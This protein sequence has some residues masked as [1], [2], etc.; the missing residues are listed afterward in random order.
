MINLLHH[1]VHS[2]FDIMERSGSLLSELKSVKLYKC[3]ILDLSKAQQLP[4]YRY[5]IERYL[6][7]LK[8]KPSN[9]RQKKNVVISELVRELRSIWIFMNISPHPRKVVHEKVTKYLEEFDKLRDYPKVK[10]SNL[11]NERFEKIASVLENGFD[12]KA[13]NQTV[14]DK[15]V[16][17]Y[18][19]LYGDEEKLLY[20]DNC[21][22]S[23]GNACSRIR[24]CDDVYTSWWRAT[25]ARR[26]KWVLKEL[27]KRQD[28]VLKDQ[29][30]LKK[31]KD[32]A[33]MSSHSCTDDAGKVNEPDFEK[34]YD[35]VPPHYPTVTKTRPRLDSFAS[36]K[37]R[38]GPSLVDSRSDFPQI[39]IRTGYKTFNMDVEEALVMMESKFKVDGRKAPE[40]LAYIAD[41][42]FKQE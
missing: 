15:H 26:D 38:A 41:K 42:L 5:L 30:T 1:V 23:E 29:I 4:T 33:G 25:K 39:P 17:L 35:F 27:K 6:T 3:D 9:L 16:N 32:D 24:F 11:F 2:C 19:V 37:T 31:L 22:A 8:E 21:V 20:N 7:L 28:N 13:S 14:I 36:P 34:D 10:R 18:G 40:L 12:I